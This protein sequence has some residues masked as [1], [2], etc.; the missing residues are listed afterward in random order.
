[1]DETNLRDWGLEIK[2]VTIDGEDYVDKQVYV[3]FD[4]LGA[5]S[6]HTVV[7]RQEKFD[8]EFT[9]EALPLTGEVRVH[10]GAFER[11]PADESDF[12]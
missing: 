6:Y 8:R 2:Q 4:P 3:R 7:L 1:M 5:A 12:K 9:V 10:D 11:E